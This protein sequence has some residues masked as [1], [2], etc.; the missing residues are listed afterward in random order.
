MGD[1]DYSGGGG[2]AFYGLIDSAPEIM[3]PRR[4]SI[5]LVSDLVSRTVFGQSSLGLG[6][7]LFVRVCVC[8]CMCVCLCICV[9]M[10]VC[11]CICV[12]ICVHCGSDKPFPS[13]SIYI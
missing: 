8:V 9:C 4:K 3:R 2:D 1:D 6:K 10:C 5:P 11:L 7:D 12:C 13:L